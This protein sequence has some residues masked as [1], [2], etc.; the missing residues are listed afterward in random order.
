MPPPD[1]S[2]AES[3][4]DG[5]SAVTSLSVPAHAQV[6]DLT[7][8]PGEIRTPDHSVRSRVL[9][10]TELRAQPARSLP[11]PGGQRTTTTAPASAQPQFAAT[12]ASLV[13][14]QLKFPSRLEGRNTSRQIGKKPRRHCTVRGAH[15]IAVVAPKALA[16]VGLVALRFALCDLRSPQGRDL[17]FPLLLAFRFESGNLSSP[18]REGSHRSNN[19]PSHRNPCITAHQVTSSACRTANDAR[20]PRRYKGTLLV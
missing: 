10:P 5:P 7:G 14:V 9:Y 1:E 4:S 16:I 8:A 11:T 13:S 15:R 20:H 3:R 19:Q 12:R 6:F 17:R 18:I 2:R